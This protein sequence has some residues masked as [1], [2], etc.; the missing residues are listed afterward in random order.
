M[1]RLL[2]KS[3][4]PAMIWDEATDAIIGENYGSEESP[5]LVWKTYHFVLPSCI[6]CPE[7]LEEKML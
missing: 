2:E 7:G 3:Q 5:K 6:R 4:V 1:K